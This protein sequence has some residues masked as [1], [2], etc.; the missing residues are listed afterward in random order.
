LFGLGEVLASVDAGREFWR[1]GP[2][3]VGDI[4]DYICGPG[5]AKF[6]G[7]HMGDEFKY[8]SA[9]EFRKRHELALLRAMFQALR[10]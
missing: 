5:F 9:Q 3:V 6:F 2:N 4:L 8:S 7:P 10:G 1:D